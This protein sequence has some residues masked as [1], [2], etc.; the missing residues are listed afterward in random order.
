MTTRV[1]EGCALIALAVSALVIINIALVYLTYGVILR[2]IFPALPALDVWGYVGMT[3]VLMILG[4]FFR[5][6]G[7]R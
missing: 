2:S 1:G 7:K 6:S 4:G 3:V 5:S